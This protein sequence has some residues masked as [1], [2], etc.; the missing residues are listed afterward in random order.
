MEKDI[1]NSFKTVSEVEAYKKSI[2][3]EC[4]SRIEFINMVKKADDLSNKSFGYIKECFE[5]LSPEL[6]NTNGGK[7]ILNKYLS[8]VNGNKNLLI[9]RSICEAIRKGG[10][11][12]NYP[13]FMNKILEATG[14]IDRSSLKEDVKSLGLVLAEGYS[15]IGKK[16]EKLLPSE[17][18][19]LY[20]AIDYITENVANL[21]HMTEYANAMMIIEEHLKSKDSVA[22]IFESKK[23]EDLASELLE[24]FNKKYS[25]TLS[26]D[27]AKVLKEIASSENRENVFNKYKESCIEKISEAKKKFDA[28]G[29]GGSSKRLENVIEQVNNKK[30]NLDTIGED[31]CNL[32]EL[33]NIFE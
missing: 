18:K 6:F 20:A 21:N 15:Y 13:F 25:D 14:K 16:A 31:V 12:S 24:E 7:T 3:E 30:F 1:I 2:I 23:L 11:E 27:E 22:N 5:A 19:K 28:T 32:I 8:T 29:D 9:L 4:N 33:S 26:E 10:K 17:D